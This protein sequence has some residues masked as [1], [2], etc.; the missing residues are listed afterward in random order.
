MVNK[1]PA[2]RVCA[3]K[4]FLLV[5]LLKAFLYYNQ[6]NYKIEIL[7]YLQ[8]CDYIQ[9]LFHCFPKAYKCNHCYNIIALDRIEAV[10]PLEKETFIENISDIEEYY[11]KAVGVTIMDGE[12]VEKVVFIVSGLTAKYID[13]KPLH[14]SAIQKWLPDG[15]LQITLNVVINYELEHLLLSYADSI[16]IL[17]PQRLI[18]RHKELLKK[19]LEKYQE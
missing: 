17:S 14:P 6:E 4:F 5:L 7:W 9:T 19:S 15:T 10:E 13:S 8:I 1:L 12:P 16:K 18:D 3:A 11:D 2:I